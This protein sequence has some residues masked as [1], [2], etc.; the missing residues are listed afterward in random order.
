MYGEDFDH[1]LYEGCLYARKKDL[2][3]NTPIIQKD[4][5]IRL[6][7]NDALIV[8]YIELDVDMICVPIEDDQGN[9]VIDITDIIDVHV[10]IKFDEWIAEHAKKDPNFE[11]HDVNQGVEK[12]DG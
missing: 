2:A 8:D 3:S 10:Y 5:R 7:G 1:E 6:D 9:A 12:T 11:W 4:M